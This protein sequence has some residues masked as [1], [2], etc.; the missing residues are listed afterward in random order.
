MFF[1]QKSNTNYQQHNIINATSSN[2]TD[3]TFTLFDVNSSYVDTYGATTVKYSSSYSVDYEGWIR[4]AENKYKCDRTEVVEH[5][6]ELLTPG[7]S[8]QGTYMT[9][10]YVTVQ[11][12]SDGSLTIRL[13]CSTTQSG[14]VIAEHKDKEN[15]PQ[16]Y[17]LLAEGT[18]TDFE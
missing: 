16:W 14:K 5:F 2:D 11:I 10:K 6:R 7:L 13:Y 3:A 9:Y 17:M 18:I 15:K 1:L 4:V 8:N 12:N